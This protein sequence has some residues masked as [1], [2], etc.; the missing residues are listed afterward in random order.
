MIA[1]SLSEE[2]RVRSDRARDGSRSKLN[3]NE[4]FENQSS[5]HT[6]EKKSTICLET[7]IQWANRLTDF[8]TTEIV[9][10][11]QRSLRVQLI[12]YFIEAA[13]QCFRLHNFNS[14]IAILG[15]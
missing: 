5:A 7:Y 11:T 9:K 12:N 15:R 6:Y 13:D 3:N 10:H 14:L 1:K 2:A 4:L 8:V